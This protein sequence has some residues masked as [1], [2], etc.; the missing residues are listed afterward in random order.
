VKSKKEVPGITRAATVDEVMDMAYVVDTR[1]ELRTGG[2]IYGTYVVD[3]LKIMKSGMRRFHV[4]HGSSD[5]WTEMSEKKMREQF[6]DYGFWL[7]DSESVRKIKKFFKMG[8]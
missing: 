8:D 4:F 2:S 3:F 6:K 5:C 7:D 1:L